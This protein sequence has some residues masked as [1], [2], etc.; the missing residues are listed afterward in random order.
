ML[1]AFKITLSQLNVPYKFH[2]KSQNVEMFV[3]EDL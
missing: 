1:S 3:L 2:R